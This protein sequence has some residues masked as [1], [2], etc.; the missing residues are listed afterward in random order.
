MAWYCGQ[1]LALGA[2]FWPSIAQTE[3]T[4]C[5]G[6]YFLQLVQTFCCG[7]IL[8]HSVLQRCWIKPFSFLQR[9]AR[10]CGLFPFIE[11]VIFTMYVSR[12]MDAQQYTQVS[13]HPY[14]SVWR[15]GAQCVCKPAE[16]FVVP[17]WWRK[18][19]HGAYSEWICLHWLVETQ[20]S[21][22]RAVRKETKTHKPGTVVK[23]TEIIC[24]A[25]A[26]NINNYK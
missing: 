23:P 21:S 14:G 2:L 5:W 25:I 16:N 3:F 19:D 12:R 18:R 26:P 17:W 4:L 8:I 22:E 10:S 9:F 24:I 15:D 7:C 1:S 13:Q 20:R 6:N 11:D